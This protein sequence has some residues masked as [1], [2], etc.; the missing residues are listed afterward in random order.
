MNT[1][2]EA[3]GLITT[4]QETGE[5][6]ELMLPIG[7]SIQQ[8]PAMSSTAASARPRF[9]GAGGANEPWRPSTWSALTSEIAISGLAVVASES[10]L[11]IQLGIAPFETLKS[12]VRAS[13]YWPEFVTLAKGHQVEETWIRGA[14][15]RLV[16]DWAEAEQEV[17][18]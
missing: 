11:A 8:P 16:L 1:K 5:P 17:A 10:L 12:N 18:A 13:V 14:L 4:G 3:D 6:K 2:K 15:G 9:S 7:A